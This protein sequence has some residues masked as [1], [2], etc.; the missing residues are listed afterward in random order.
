MHVLVATDGSPNS[1]NAAR[2]AGELLRPADRV[3]L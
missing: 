1:L 3:T 2:R